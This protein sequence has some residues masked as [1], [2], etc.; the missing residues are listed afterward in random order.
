MPGYLYPSFP[1]R[2]PPE[3]DGKQPAYAV[4]IVGGGPVGLT[5]ALDLAERGQSCVVL[6]AASTVS[7]GSRAI[8][9]SK[10]S[11]EILDRFGVAEPMLRRGFTWNGGRVYHG[12]EEIYRF[13]LP[14]EPDEKFPAFVNLQQYLTEEMLLAAVAERAQWIDL[15]WQSRVDGLRLEPGGAVLHVATPEG[16]YDLPARF[17]VACDGARSTVRAL[18]AVPFEGRV[19]EDHFL[20]ADVEVSPDLPSSERRFWF[21]PEFHP[22]ETALLHR[23]GDGLWRVDFQ[24]GWDG[25]DAQA[26]KAPERALPRIRA[27]LGR[28]DVRLHWASVYTFQ[29]RRIAQLRHGP[30]F[31]AGDAAHQVSPFGARGGNSGIQD[32]D[33]L[34]W[35]LALVLSGHAPDALLDSYHAERSTA[36]DENIRITSRTTDF[37]TAKTAMRA[38]LRTAVLGLAKRHGFARALVN[39]GRLS[40]ATVYRDSPLNG[41][42]QGFAGGPPPGA[43]CANLPASAN[44]S[45]GYL[46]DG[47]G[48]DIQCD[49]LYFNAESANPAA[50]AK[51]AAI[52]AAEQ[53]LSITCVG[54][55]LGNHWF[56]ADPTG[57]IARAFAARP[58]SVY[59]LRPDQH[60]AAR[61]R[62]LDTERVIAGIRRALGHDLRRADGRT[63]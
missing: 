47:L 21:L 61:W 45:D 60:V 38:R 62:T 8:C 9:W 20:I 33:N 43:P 57:R 23:Q 54:Q 16:G 22:G 25:V 49:L 44:P 14:R 40:T 7:E 32:A 27:M 39:S 56:Q 29:A 1:F 42:D 52:Q 11:L 41:D 3:L 51:L 53:P 10:R 28:Q 19:F 63:A 18:M 30:V 46:L 58:D 15:R 31:F 50:L 34:G 13:T 36:A 5:L 35:K 48:T 55:P 12:A 37:M 6:Q 59:L 4:A 17:V 24:L 2:R 26:E